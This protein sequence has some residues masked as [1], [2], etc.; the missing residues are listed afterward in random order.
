M[1]FLGMVYTITLAWA[2]QDHD[3]MISN[4]YHGRDCS[5]PIMIPCSPCKSDTALYTAPLLEFCF[6]QLILCQNMQRRFVCLTRNIGF[7]GPKCR[8]LYTVCIAWHCDHSEVHSKR[9]TFY[10]LN[11]NGFL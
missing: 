9:Q 7:T 10:F 11:L 8:Y 1:T 6:F 2:T 4:L 3:W 5:H